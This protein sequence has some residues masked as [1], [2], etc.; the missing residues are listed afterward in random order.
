PAPGPA[1]GPAL[2]PA[3]ERAFDETAELIR[4]R[5]EK[6]ASLAD[7]YVREGKL[8]VEREEFRL[9]LASYDKALELDPDNAEAIAGRRLAQALAEDR[10]R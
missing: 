4:L 6:R 10:G 1:P 2:D 7:H 9:A 8:H 3:V 5:R